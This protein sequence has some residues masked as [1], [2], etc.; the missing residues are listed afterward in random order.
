M[1]KSITQYIEKRRRDYDNPTWAI[2]A[3]EINRQFQT[4][5]NKE[6]L[7][8]W[9]RRQNTTMPMPVSVPCMFNPITE[10]TDKRTLVISDLHC[11]YHNEEFIQKVVLNG[12]KNDIEQIIIAGDLID[13]DSLSK[14]SKSH[15]IARL[16]T[17]L[18]ITG[19]MVLYLANI[20][21]LFITKGNHDA[22]WFDKLDAPMSFDR[23][24]NATLNGRQPKNKI[25]TTE[26]DFVFVGT[27]FVVGH[28]DKAS[29]VPGKLAHGI[30]QKFSRHAL[31]GHEHITGV[32]QGDPIVRYLGVSLGCCADPKKFWYSERRLNSS[33]FMSNGYAIID[34]I[35]TFSL[36]DE[37]H[38]RYFTRRYIQD[39]IY[40]CFGSS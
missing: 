7:R 9:Y 17:E 19:Q 27:N 22:R 1:D 31:T 11:P 5:Y 37:N 10:I 12:I 4:L 38:V 2:L 34:G 30:A 28:V 24:I 15:N 25:T 39:G 40:N 35:D 14:Y 33:P 20:A 8:S 23:L 18:E 16:E 32:F 21:P 13:L 26:R 36:F 3:E 6:S 29:S